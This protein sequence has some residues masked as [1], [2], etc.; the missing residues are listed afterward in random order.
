MCVRARR[1]PRVRCA[2]RLVRADSS[3]L[4]AESFYPM[5][6]RKIPRRH[7]PLKGS[8]HFR[9][10]RGQE[11]RFVPKKPNNRSAQKSH[12]EAISSPKMLRQRGH[13]RARPLRRG[14]TSK[15]RVSASRCTVDL[16]GATPTLA[17]ACLSLIA[18]LPP[19]G[20][21]SRTKEGC[22]C[23]HLPPPAHQ[24][25]ALVGCPV[26]FL[27]GHQVEFQEICHGSRPR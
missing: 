7:S 21:A 6:K 26:S 1:P 2:H 15:P 5:A 18:R 12:F 16:V 11:P 19:V 4:T 24:L 10:L 20:S 3:S 27:H 22:I 25:A 14:T 23:I 9:R 8:G 13:A 17:W